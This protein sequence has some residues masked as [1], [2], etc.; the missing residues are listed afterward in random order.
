MLFSQKL[1]VWD[2]FNWKQWLLQGVLQQPGRMPW[3]SA[4]L[5]V[6]AGNR[7]SYW[8]NVVYSLHWNCRVWQGHG[9]ALGDGL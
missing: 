3:D 6:E 7:V 1:S 8:D 2:G 5:Q 9:D 4:S